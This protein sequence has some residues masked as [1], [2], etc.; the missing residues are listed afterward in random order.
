MEAQKTIDAMEKKR[1]I[2]EQALK[3]IIGDRI[4][5]LAETWK[6]TWKAPKVGYISWKGIAQ[7]IAG[8][9]AV[10]RAVIE[11]HTGEATRRFRFYEK[12]PK[13]AEMPE[14]LDLDEALEGA[15]ADA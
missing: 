12:D 9:R 5:L 10:P 3:E 2:A 4:G 7:E 13:L 1:D 11:K 15:A 14:G 6:A 8:R